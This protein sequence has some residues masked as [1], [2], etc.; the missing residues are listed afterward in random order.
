[1]E[2]PLGANIAAGACKPTEASGIQNPVLRHPMYIAGSQKRR[3]GTG[4]GFF[5]RQSAL[6]FAKW[7]IFPANPSPFRLASPNCAFFPNSFSPKAFA[8]RRWREQIKG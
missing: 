6:L 1:M 2:Y 5:T 3:H 7:E 8:S 4:G